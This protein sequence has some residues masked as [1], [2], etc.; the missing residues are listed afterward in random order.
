MPSRTEVRRRV[1]G[2]DV[3]GAH[4][5]AC[6]VEDGAV[7]DVAPWPCP[8]WQGLDRLDAALASARARWPAAWDADTA[9]RATMTAEMVDLFATR[10][11][12]V[13]RLGTHL[14]EAL[15]P[16]LRLYSLDGFVEPPSA[17]THWKEIASANWHATARLVAP[18]VVDGLLLDIG[19][20][21]TDIIACVGG[22]VKARG[23]DDAH[24]LATGELVYHGVVRTPLCALAPRVVLDGRIV[25]V[26][27]EFF[28]TTADVYRLTGELDAAHDQATPADG[29]ERSPAASRRRIARM[30]G[31]DA[32][33]L[34]DAQWLELAQDW[35]RAQC[36]EIEG[37]VLRVASASGL[38]A[39]APMVGAGC[40]AFLA[41]SIAFRAG[42]SFRR[43]ADVV[44]AARGVAWAD[45][46]A[47]AVAVALLDG[48]D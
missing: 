25:N 42:R 28:A 21:T 37:Q 18:R 8:L 20:T 22:R 9:H 7:R 12:G 38:P 33:D 19:S 27:N 31:R 23:L 34:P 5:K 29:G 46:C 39:D 43:L 13:V 26:M 1:V 48:E 16:S 11:E 10:E 15:G 36:D 24:R 32:H 44:P 2:W 35:R 3:G 41:A 45:V 47:P 40:G 4:L 17:R 14:A 6:L 30:V